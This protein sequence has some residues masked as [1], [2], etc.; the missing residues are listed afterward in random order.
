M[1]LFDKIGSI[2]VGSLKEYCSEIHFFGLGFIQVKLGATFRMHFYNSN[3]PAIVD[4]EEIHNHRYNFHSKVMAGTF[5]QIM[6]SVERNPGSEDT[7][8]VLEEESCKQDVKVMSLPKPVAIHKISEQTYTAGS[9]Y[10]VDHTLFH[11]VQA[12]FAI[13]FLRRESI[14][15]DNAEV[16]RKRNAEKICPFSKKIP[17]AKLWEIVEQMLLVASGTNIPD[18]IELKIA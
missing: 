5:R 4:L 10:F 17:D 16:I 6:Y 15:K 1:Y 12:N 14:M 3:L 8:F 2:S 13:T 9:S 7:E 11:Q 18:P